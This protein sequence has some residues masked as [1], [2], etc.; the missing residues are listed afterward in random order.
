[1]VMH[2]NINKLLNRGRES[3]EPSMRNICPEGSRHLKSCPIYVSNIVRY[4]CTWQAALSLAITVQ[5]H[6]CIYIIATCWNVKRRSSY[7]FNES[8]EVHNAR[9]IHYPCTCIA[10]L[11]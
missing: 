10:L 4:K 5:L 3:I 7:I 1:M 11:S 8:T 2:F 9:H 6:Q